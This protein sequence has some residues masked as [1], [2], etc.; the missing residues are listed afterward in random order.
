MV[1][2]IS[3]AA[4][5]HPMANRSTYV[6][7]ESGRP[8]VLVVP[9]TVAALRRYAFSTDGGGGAEWHARGDELFFLSQGNRL[10]SVPVTMAAGTFK[11]GTPAVLSR[12]M[13]Q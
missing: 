11:A 9:F 5:F 7:N 13:R 10:M 12:S 1:K 4:G 2:G 8:E 3:A 6:S